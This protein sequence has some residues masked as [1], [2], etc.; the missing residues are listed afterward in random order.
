MKDKRVASAWQTRHF[1]IRS[2]KHTSIWEDTIWSKLSESIYI[3]RGNLK[4]PEET[5]RMEETC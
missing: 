4:E 2:S 5:G 3:R 1:K